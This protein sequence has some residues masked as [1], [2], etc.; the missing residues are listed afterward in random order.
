LTTQEHRSVVANRGGGGQRALIIGGT[1]KMG[2]WFAQFL[3]SQGFGIEIAD[4]RASTG[5]GVMHDWRE[6]SLEQDYIVVAAPLAASNR[7][8]EELAVRRPR[9][10]IFDVG[11]LKSPLRSGLE[12]LRS[13]GLRV[14]SIH[15]M[16]GPDA[17]LLSG[18][19]VIFIDLKAGDA[20][21]KTRSL[22]R[23]TMA[24]QVV[25]ELEEHDRLIAY[26][27]GL[28]HA[29]NLA[30]LSALNGSGESAVRLLELS[31]T[32]FD[33]QFDIARAVAQEN[34]ELYFEIQRL[35]EYGQEAL[36][37]LSR[38]VQNL[39]SSVLRNDRTNFVDH[40][41]TLA[42]Y[43]QSRKMQPRP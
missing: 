12:A 3:E 7:I 38:A 25:M 39:A 15:P 28:S 35:N 24:E 36:D 40:M 31:S 5:P 41:R 43:T 6:S 4:P 11:S 22:F 17:E 42:K 1:G 23:A 34:P 10:V 37:A 27:L 26:V 33:A 19:H 14:T 29:V 13:A 32:T 2:G 8:L 16:F 18:R 21:E 9:G 30:F 20:F